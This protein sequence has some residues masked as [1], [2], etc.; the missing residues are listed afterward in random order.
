M[1]QAQGES[2]GTATRTFSC[3]IVVNKQQGSSE[4]N[5]HQSSRISPLYSSLVVGVV[6]FVVFFSARDWEYPSPSRLVQVS[7]AVEQEQHSPSIAVSQLLD[8]ALHE[9]G[10]MPSAPSSQLKINVSGLFP[11]EKWP[12]ELAFA[13]NDKC[14][15]VLATSHRSNETIRVAPRPGFFL[16]CHAFRFAIDRGCSDKR[17]GGWLYRHRP[18]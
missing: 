18:C 12:T 2:R 9:G 14:K 13:A 6:L 11:L 7:D 5:T 17:L 16:P 8:V 4:V 1:E 3:P 15:S 10:S